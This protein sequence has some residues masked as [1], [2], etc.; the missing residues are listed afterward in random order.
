MKQAFP[1]FERWGVAGV[2]IGFMNRDDQ[3]MVNFYNNATREAA[4]HHLL[5]DFHGAFKAY[6]HA[7]NLSE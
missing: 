2:K 1:V 6:R 7:A 5:V 4:M 3:E